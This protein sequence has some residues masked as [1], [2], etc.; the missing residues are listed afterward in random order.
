MLYPH[1]TPSR[2]L[3]NLSG[4][5]D[6]QSD[7]DETGEARG[8]SHA[9]PD[10]RPLAV[11][12]S[13]N[14]QY[15][16]LYDYLGMGWHLRRIHLPS[17]W[18]DQRVFLRVGSANYR[19]VVWV[20]GRRA[21]EHEGGH[22]PFAFEI[23]DLVHFDGENVIA[24]QVENHLRPDRVPSGG[25]GELTAGVFPGHPATTFD[26]YPYTGIH[27]P[28]LLYTVPQDFIEDLTVVTRLEGRSARVEVQ[29]RVNGGQTAGRVVLQGAGEKIEAGVLFEAGEG[30]ASL[31]VPSARLWSPAD[32]YLYELTVTAGDDHYSL[33]VGLRTVEVRGK[34]FLLNGQPIQ[35]KGFGRHEDFYASGRGLNL[36]LLVKD[37]D[38]LDWVGANSYRTSHY[39]Y[40]EE[41]MAMADR[42]G[43]LI[44][45]EIPA[46][47]LQFEDPAAVAARKVV[48]LRQIEALIARDK[49]HPAVVM[50]SVANEP[51]L[52]HP[53][54][55][56]TG[57]EDS[58]VPAFSRD[59][60]RD[61]VD[62]ARELDPTR[63]VTLVGMMG[64]PLEWQALT[65]VIC[66]NRYWGWYEQGAQLER[67]LTS[68]DQELDLLYETFE[69]PILISEF[70]ADTVAGL[71]GQPAL[72]WS[73]EYQ[74]GLIRGYLEVARRKD[75]VIGMHVW[76]FADFQAVQ[77]IRRV[78]G[79]NL[80]GV[81]TRARQ[82]KL[83]AHV[84]REYWK[85]PAAP[86][87]PV[88]RAGPSFQPVSPEPPVPGPDPVSEG[89]IRSLLGDVACRLD[90][91]KPG[92]TTTLTFDFGREG[93]W[94]FVIVDGAVTLAEGDGDS[95]AR[96]TMRAATALKIF[97]GRLD[98]LAAV[99]AGR[100]RVMGDLAALSILRDL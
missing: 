100:V 91:T 27:R 62:R 36:P 87:G 22:L 17:F 26:F 30:P 85:D 33:P 80:K 31:V 16:D 3:L 89:D 44:I 51:M 15:A 19:A 57:Q 90:G 34:E 25:M 75:F 23:T 96:V 48:C 14:E 20:N 42:E 52:P 10:P 18:E 46:V 58:P 59:F 45:D 32:P 92:L 77:S 49:N 29:V 5:W 6:F 65:D 81:F 7:P 61:L 41:E 11:P 50:W 63:P 40:S 53:I 94:R 82:P 13:W 88:P 8:F 78:G 38:L 71:H 79:M 99:V 67:A 12:G 95:A 66:V 1:Q 64:A 98:P 39:P 56:L 54:A 24:I 76:N 43:F 73:E 35:F 37:Y 47:S 21:G 84:L 83:A 68:L 55:R 69:K 97:S 4:L 86:A 60:F 2:Y 70:G 28:V 72:M 93:I 74:A 9:L